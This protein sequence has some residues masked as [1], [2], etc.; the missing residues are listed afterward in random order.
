MK[1]LSKN[2]QRQDIGF[3]HHFPV[4]WDSGNSGVLEFPW[5][6]PPTT[7]SFFPS[8]C[9]PAHMHTDSWN[10]A[11]PHPFLGVD[12]I[13]L[14]TWRVWAWGRTRVWVS[15]CLCI[16]NCAENHQN[17]KR[18][19]CSSH[20]MSENERKCFLR[21]TVLEIISDAHRCLQQTRF[22]WR[23]KVQTKAPDNYSL[24]KPDFDS[25]HISRCVLALLSISAM[26]SVFDKKYKQ[27]RQAGRS[28]HMLIVILGGRLLSSEITIWRSLRLSRLSVLISS[29]RWQSRRMLPATPGRFKPWHVQ[30]EMVS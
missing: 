28:R 19:V 9:P 2:K 29:Y 11:K 23:F 5:N 10:E 25:S 22:L 6:W 1:E 30:T 26:L 15:V 7:P 24:K 21:M 13:R 12:E 4:S 20:I 3:I 18:T 14:S 16:Y 17:P 8:V 27:S